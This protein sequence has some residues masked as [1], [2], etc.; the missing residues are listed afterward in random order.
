MSVSTTH[1]NLALKLLGQPEVP[2]CELQHLGIE[3]FPILPLLLKKVASPQK[4]RG[5]NARE[6]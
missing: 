1:H 2:V 6:K 5:R 3:M 4:D